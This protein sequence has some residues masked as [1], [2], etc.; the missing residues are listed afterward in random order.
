M[1][2]LDPMQE[3]RLLVRQRSFADFFA[4]NSGYLADLGHRTAALEDSRV[5]PLVAQRR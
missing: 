4:F 5:L 3:R 2:F 1:D